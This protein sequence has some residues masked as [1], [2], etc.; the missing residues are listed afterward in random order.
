MLHTLRTMMFSV[1]VP[2][3]SVRMYSTC[4]YGP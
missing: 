2:V 3:L 4:T 1:R